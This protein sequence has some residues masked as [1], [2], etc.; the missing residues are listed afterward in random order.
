MGKN[1][2][3]LDWALVR[4]ERLQGLARPANEVVRDVE[5]RV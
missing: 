1:K 4:A 2:K 5:V 3:E